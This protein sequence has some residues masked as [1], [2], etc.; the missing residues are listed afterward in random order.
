MVKNYP[1]EQKV[2]GSILGKAL[3]LLLLFYLFCFVIC[4]LFLLASPSRGSAIH[5]F[6]VKYNYTP[7]LYSGRGRSPSSPSH[8]ERKQIKVLPQSESLLQVRGLS[9]FSM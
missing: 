5:A 9:V 4:F 8:F 2:L 6:L 1:S 7:E 3:V